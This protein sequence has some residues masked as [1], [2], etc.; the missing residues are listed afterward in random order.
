MNKINL[1]NF[2]VV[3]SVSKIEKNIPHAVFLKSEMTDKMT[4]VFKMRITNEEKVSR[5]KAIV[6]PFVNSKQF[7]KEMDEVL[8][9]TK[10]YKAKN[11]PK[12]YN[13]LLTNN[14][15]IR[16]LTNSNN[17]EVFHHFI[18]E[19]K[20]EYLTGVKEEQVYANDVTVFLPE[21]L[22]FNLPTE[23]AK[24]VPTLQITE[25]TKRS[26]KVI[27]ANLRLLEEL[28]ESISQ[29]KNKRIDVLKKTEKTKTNTDIQKVLSY[30]KRDEIELKKAEQIISKDY[31][32]YNTD[33]VA[34]IPVERQVRIGSTWVNASAIE[35]SINQTAIASQVHHMGNQHALYDV[36][37]D[38]CN[39]KN[40]F[41]VADLKIVEVE[42][43]AYRPSEIAHINNV[44][45][46][47]KQM[48]K[49][50]RL[51]RTETFESF[52]QQDEFS[53][54][55]DTQSTERFSLERS[56]QSIIE[57]QQ[58]FNVDGSVTASYGLVRG[59]INTGYNTSNSSTN[60]N[61]NAQQFAK[62]FVQKVIDKS[63]QI[64]RTERS[65]KTAEEFEETVKHEVDNQAG[66]SPKSYVYRW[67]NKM[68]KGTLKNYGKRLMI[69]LTI[70][71][72]S[73]YYLSRLVKGETGTEETF[74]LTDPRKLT[75]ADLSPGCS[76][77]KV[78]PSYLSED[79]YISIADKYNAKLE[80]PPEPIKIISESKAEYGE[81]V[82]LAHN[83]EIV[84]PEGYY[85]EE[86]TFIFTQDKIGV[87]N[88]SQ[89]DNHMRMFIGTTSVYDIT[90]H[91]PLTTSQT[92]SLGTI[93]YE[94][95]T[96]YTSNNT[97]SASQASTATTKGRIRLN[98][99]E[100]KL[101]IVVTGGSLHFSYTVEVTCIAKPET[102]VEWQLQSYYALIEAYEG[103]KEAS[104]SKSDSY[105]LENL[106]MHP[107]KKKEFIRTE[108]KR[109]ALKKMLDC[110]SLGASFTLNDSYKYGNEYTMDCCLDNVN[111]AQAEFLERVFEWDNMTFNFHPYYHT[112]KSE[113]LDLL[114]LEDED[115]LF[116]SFLRA[117]YVTLQIPVQRDRDKEIAAINF[118]YT[119]AINST[120]VIPANAEPLLAELMNHPANSTV[121]I[122]GQPIQIPNSISDIGFFEMPTDL[123]ILEKGTEDG[124]DVRPYPENPAA[125][126]S[127]VII[128]KVYT[129]GIITN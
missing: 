24:E 87:S 23:K 10:Q 63:S 126:N 9:L 42:T 31:R 66:V 54:E 16:M 127:N 91:L 15:V 121:G 74:T 84:I 96:G 83:Y 67:L 11:S 37:S 116:E 44:Q 124:V 4:E 110:N 34:L 18:D 28:K 123:V 103:M 41:K 92:P 1:L 73:H 111:G 20:S 19:I 118:I 35:N 105:S 125:P 97:G 38:E 117:S 114:K 90:Q 60:A 33:A 7:A 81:N 68:V 80:A 65:F 21:G 39:L 99:Q 119:N 30:V 5:L 51:K 26:E 98:K 13:E 86:C 8:L 22:L 70:A 25:P 55:T 115:P 14:I 43:V 50:R 76:D 47:E 29:L 59:T 85:A 17:N 12:E 77:V 71:H 88:S 40:A 52:F 62:E 108:L 109:E 112:K 89:N 101:G 106:G 2:A 107:L 94:E 32:D 3:R 36:L 58:A 95:N 57:K 120:A 49:N 102:H 61:A 128:P 75:F 45:P 69:E 100:N 6:E 78:L 113:W 64:I 72:P 53:K 46:G 129:P 93:A 104:N 122:N 79:N 56:A 27:F 48:K 82:K